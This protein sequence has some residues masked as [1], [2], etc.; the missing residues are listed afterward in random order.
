MGSG[1]E[2]KVYELGAISAQNAS[3]EAELVFGWRRLDE[4][5][6]RPLEILSVIV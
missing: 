1:S 5:L 3:F 4:T 6:R 2:V